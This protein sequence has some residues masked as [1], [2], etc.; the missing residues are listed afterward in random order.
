MAK[1]QEEEMNKLFRTVLCAGLLFLITGCVSV[2]HNAFVTPIGT[3]KFPKDVELEGLDIIKQGTNLI[4]SVEKY[5]SKNNPNVIAAS[6]TGQAE[7]IKASLEGG[8]TIA[9]EVVSKLKKP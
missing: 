9:G 8:A 3:F 5:K 2:P 1:T 6:A 7:L 4:I